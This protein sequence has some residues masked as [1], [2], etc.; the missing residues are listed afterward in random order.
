MSRWLKHSPDTFPIKE[1]DHLIAVVVAAALG[2]GGG[3]RARAV[4]I[5]SVQFSSV[6]QSGPTLCDPMN[7]STPGLPVH[8]QP[9]EFT[10]THVHRVRNAIQPSHPLS[11]PSPPAPNSFLASESF[12]VSQL[13][14]WGGQS[15]GVSASASFPPKKFQ[16]WSPSGLVGSPCSLRDSQESSPTPQ[17]K[18]IN[19]SLLSFLHSPTFTPIHEYWKNHSLDYD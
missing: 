10:Q 8:Y 2:G 19:S 5:Y 13:F 4:S 15:I 17:F 9:P 14:S 16:G 12:P 3:D 18:S 11:S 6:A 1:D 7:R